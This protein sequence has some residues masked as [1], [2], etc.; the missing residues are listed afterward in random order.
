LIFNMLGFFVARV[1]AKNK[2]R[3]SICLSF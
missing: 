3:S 2:C 1:V